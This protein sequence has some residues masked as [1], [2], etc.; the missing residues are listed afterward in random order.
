MFY[1]FNIPIDTYDPY[2]TVSCELV[3]KHNVPSSGIH[4]PDEKNGW[5]AEVV[6]IGRR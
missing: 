2:T 5:K 1:I 4:L 6:E 3:K